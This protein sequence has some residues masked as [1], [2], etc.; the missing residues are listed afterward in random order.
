MCFGCSKEPSHRNGSFEYP[1]HMFWLRNQENTF[2]VRTATKIF[3]WHRY[4]SCISSLTLYLLLSSADN[5]C[6]QFV[7]RSG[8]TK[9]R[10]WYGSNLFDTQI[11]FLKEFFKK[12]DFKKNQQMKIFPGGKVLILYYWVISIL[13][14]SRLVVKDVVTIT[15]KKWKRKNDIQVNH[16]SADV[17]YEISSIIWY[18]IEVTAWATGA[19]NNGCSYVGSPVLSDFI[20]LKLNIS[21]RRMLFQKIWNICCKILFDTLRIYFIQ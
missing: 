11:V 8:P 5:L 15:H 9:P 7:S 14:I 10:A 4:L 6:K 12:I 2:Q 18:A 1:Q 16:L 13:K 21:K 20:V 19:V 3:I 17:S